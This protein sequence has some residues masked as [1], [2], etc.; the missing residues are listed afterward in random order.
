MQASVAVNSYDERGNMAEGKS[1]RNTHKMCV[2]FLIKG[3]EAQKSFDTMPIPDESDTSLNKPI[4]KSIEQFSNQED[5]YIGSVSV[6]SDSLDAAR[7][8]SEIRD[9]VINECDDS[10]LMLEDGP[11]EKFERV[12]FE[13]IAAFE[14][15]FRE[16]LIVSICNEKSSLDD[17][18]IGELE[19]KN[20]GELFEIVFTDLEFN[21]RVKRVV[22]DKNSRRFEKKDLAETIGQMEEDTLWSQYFDNDW[23][24]TV[25]EEHETIRV[26]RNDVMHAH[27][28]SYKDY[29][30]ARTL[31]EKANKE[32]GRVIYIRS[33]HV[34]FT[35]FSE[36]VSG[37][38]ES[39]SK[40][41]AQIDFGGIT[42][43]LQTL[44]QAYSAS[45]S[46]VAR[47]YS[48]LYKTL[49]NAPI[50][51]GIAS[52]INFDNLYHN[53]VA[54]EDSADS[55]DIGD[56]SSSEDTRA[57]TSSH[58]PKSDSSEK[59]EGESPENEDESSHNV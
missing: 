18:L 53:I 32:M 3:E 24:S 34:D 6:D 11:S 28:M 55:A 51:T 59:S 20:L 45:F 19:K 25:A 31:V 5:M 54:P 27:R 7:V 8:L 13:P 44:Q 40:I 46:G 2:K 22:N 16:L 9:D 39:I 29:R 50:S 14:R 42:R 38:A 4:A 12:L 36:V 33:T 56:A 48:D 52:G 57:D 15:R 23:L 58:P 21:N 10:V 37:F 47:Q 35:S 1:S 49:Y 26:F 43:S 41:I 30:R 17:K